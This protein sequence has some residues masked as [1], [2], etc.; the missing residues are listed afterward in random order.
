MKFIRFSV[1]ASVLVLGL[2]LSGCAPKAEQSDATSS[3]PVSGEKSVTTEVYS[4][5]SDL[6]QCS[7]FE[8]AIA[9]FYESKSASVRSAMWS[10]MAWK[11]Q[12]LAFMAVDED[13]QNAFYMVMDVS[14]SQSYDQM[15]SAPEEWANS[16]AEVMA[17][18][19]LGLGY[20]FDRLNAAVAQ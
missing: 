11:M 20:S 10:S 14:E 17:I 18:C 3:S 16:I 4:T 6:E 7:L 15:A 8:R 2:G 9:P 19:D 5:T 13:L 12:P 1:V